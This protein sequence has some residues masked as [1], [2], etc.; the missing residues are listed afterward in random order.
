MKIS[1]SVN[2]NFK[3]YEAERKLFA[4][5]LW[6]LNI[7]CCANLGY[8]KNSNFWDRAPYEADSTIQDG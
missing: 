7:P 1:S 6:A 5:Q 2:T 4:S 3:T 8:G